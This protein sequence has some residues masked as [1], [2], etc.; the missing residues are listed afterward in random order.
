[1][2]YRLV[3][4]GDSTGVCVCLSAVDT[5]GKKL[6]EVLYDSYKELRGV[7]CCTTTG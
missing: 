6:S 7:H 5:A 4:T 2:L 1:M 3:K